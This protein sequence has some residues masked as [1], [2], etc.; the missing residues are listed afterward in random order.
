MNTEIKLR[1][2]IRRQRRTI[3]RLK[4]LLDSKDRLLAS[5]KSFYEEMLNEKDKVAKA[6]GKDI[7]KLF[8]EMLIRTIRN[9]DT[10]TAAPKP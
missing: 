8:G 7:E 4:R 9:L 5:Q 2:R 3:R 1:D 10:A 6:D